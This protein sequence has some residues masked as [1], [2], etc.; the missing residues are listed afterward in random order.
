MGRWRTVDT[1]PMKQTC[2]LS[3]GIVGVSSLMFSRQGVTEIGRLDVQLAAK[4]AANLAVV[5]PL[6]SAATFFWRA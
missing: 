6:T 1:R 4:V 5:K 3:T 2:C